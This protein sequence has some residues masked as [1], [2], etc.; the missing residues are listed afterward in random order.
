[1]WN[2]SLMQS[3]A[4]LSQIWAWQLTDTS[5]DVGAWFAL[6]AALGVGLSWLRGLDAPAAVS[7]LGR[8]AAAQRTRQL[9]RA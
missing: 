5:I 4:V 8:T 7:Q 6:C 1:M 2:A 9:A 3:P